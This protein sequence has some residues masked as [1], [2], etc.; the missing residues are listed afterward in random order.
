MIKPNEY[1]KIWPTEETRGVT[2]NQVKAAHTQDEYFN[3]C[4]WMCGQTC[5]MMDNGE[6]AIYSH[7]YERWARQGKLAEQGVDWD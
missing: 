6:A 4:K 5:G 3:F 2:Y 7:D 1:I